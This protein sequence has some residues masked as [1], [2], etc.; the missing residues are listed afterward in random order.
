MNLA[1][2]IF[3]GMNNFGEENPEEDNGCCLCKDGKL[4]GLISSTNGFF[5]GGELKYCPECGRKL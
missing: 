2:E 4:S 5:L 3:W 1:S